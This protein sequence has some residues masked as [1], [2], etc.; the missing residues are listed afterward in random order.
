MIVKASSK[1]AIRWSNGIAVGAELRLVPARSEPEDEPAVTQFVDRRRL[2]G[3]QR[4]VVEV[5]ARDERA[6]LDP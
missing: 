4:R 5:G 3:E 6:E 2:L 1:R